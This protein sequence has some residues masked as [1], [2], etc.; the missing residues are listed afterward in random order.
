MG[1]AEAMKYMTFNSSCS[2]AGLAN[3]LS[4]YGIDAEDRT[5]ALKMG[6]PYLF[7]CED[8]QYLSGPML[9]GARWF[10]LYL[11]P[12]GFTLTE[13]RLSREEVCPYLRANSPAMLGLRVTPASKH[14][15]IYTGSKGGEHYFLNNKR[16]TSPEPETLR[17]TESDLLSRLDE[18][19]TIGILEKTKPVPVSLQ[20]YLEQSLTTLRSL[21]SE[22]T[23]FCSRE[24]S[25]AA[26]RQAMETLFRPI[27][28]DGVTM[29][30]L[31]EEEQLASSL[32][33]VRTQFM[34]AVKESR[35]AVLSSHLN[36]SL[37]TAAMT[38]YAQLIA[39]EMETICP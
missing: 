11:H 26:Q 13:H 34:K 38:E 9:Q 23:A 5:I 20:P 35:P 16:Q 18:M 1:V 21:Q 22:L 37:L 39:A 14:A 2:Y 32:R 8:G 36:M 33:T 24:Q 3:L 29:L 17:L 15:V 7:A 10:N 25:P 30:E 19:V 6:L 4:H 12:I 28:L 31:L 27:L